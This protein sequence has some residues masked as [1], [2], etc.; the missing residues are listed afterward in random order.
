MKSELKAEKLK[1]KLD[2]ESRSVKEE[3]EVK[4]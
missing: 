4:E 2:S 1:S 3:A